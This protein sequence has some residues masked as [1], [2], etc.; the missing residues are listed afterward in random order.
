[1]VWNARKGSTP[2]ASNWTPILLTIGDWVGNSSSE[3]TYIS[4][5]TVFVRGSISGTSRSPGDIGTWDVVPPVSPVL[6]VANQYYVVGRWYFY[7]FGAGYDTTGVFG[8]VAI[9]STGK[10]VFWHYQNDVSSP[11]GLMPTDAFRS[12][13]ITAS[14]QPSYIEFNATY[15]VQT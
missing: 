4:P 7:R 5:D 13:V 11:S 1:M 2:V 15:E 8:N 10:L 14:S 6:P 12:F 3:Y 9:D